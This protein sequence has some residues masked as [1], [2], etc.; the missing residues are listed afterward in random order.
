[1]RE[2]I[3]QDSAA[4]G[5]IV[6]LP[7]G[8]FPSQHLRWVQSYAQLSPVWNFPIGKKGLERW[9]QSYAQLSPVWNFPIGKKGLD[10]AHDKCHHNTVPG[11]KALLILPVPNR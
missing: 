1:M 4:K 10:L 9:V 8:Y 2:W 7:K 5:V 11:G 6:Y 3:H